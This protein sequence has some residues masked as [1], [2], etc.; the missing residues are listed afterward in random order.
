MFP[1]TAYVGANL[2]LYTA[3]V[4]RPPEGWPQLRD[5]PLEDPNPANGQP[6][7][8][9]IGADLYGSL[10][11]SDLRRG[12]LVMPTAQKAELDWIMSGPVSIDLCTVFEAHVS[13]CVSEC[14]AD[15]LL[16][17]SWDG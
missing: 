6:I 13:H 15:S 2:V 3:S 8:L 7:R 17:G 9:L 11:L 1:S 16:R 5:L 10:V 4:V 12:L 14:N